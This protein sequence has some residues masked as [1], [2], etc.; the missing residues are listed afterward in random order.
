VPQLVAV[1]S[2][3]DEQSGG[4]RRPALLDVGSH[5]PGPA[6]DPGRLRDEV[7]DSWA[8]DQFAEHVDGLV[9]AATL[10]GQSLGLEVLAKSRPSSHSPPFVDT[11][12]VGE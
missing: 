8:A 2:G 10:P 5:G 1:R 6:E 4:D 12:L 9:D 11:Y 3:E 7:L